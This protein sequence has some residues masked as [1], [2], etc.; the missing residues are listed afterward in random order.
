VSKSCAT[1]LTWFA[2]SVQVALRDLFDATSLCID[3]SR[4]RVANIKLN[5]SS[6]A[7]VTTCGKVTYISAILYS[8]DFS[9]D[10]QIA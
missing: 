6:S 1:A 2:F 4:D 10:L 3:S 7:N 5:V 8:L 9:T